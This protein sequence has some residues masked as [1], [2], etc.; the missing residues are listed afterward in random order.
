MLGCCGRDLS[1]TQTFS[2]PFPLQGFAI[3]LISLA[4]FLGYVWL[5][6]QLTTLGEPAWLAG[7]GEAEENAEQPQQQQQGAPANAPEAAAAA[8]Q[9]PQQQ[10]GQQLNDEE[11]LQQA[12]QNLGELTMLTIIQRHPAGL[13][14]QGSNTDYCSFNRLTCETALTEAA[15]KSACPRRAG[16]RLITK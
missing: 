7:E 9:P 13:S 8:G 3:V 16:F 14:L 6:E 15:T 1:S 12:V 5:R 2:F 4:A 10:Q 11:E